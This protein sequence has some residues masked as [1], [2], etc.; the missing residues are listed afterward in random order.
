MRSDC[1]WLSLRPPTA[2]SDRTGELAS[3]VRA[4]TVTRPYNGGTVTR[5][6][7]GGTVTRT[8]NV[9]SYFHCCSTTS[10]KP[11]PLHPLPFVVIVVVISSPPFPK[12][13]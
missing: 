2:G 5:T 6:Y 9:E 10:L 1:N 13:G 4:G 11:L 12:E 3:L 7:N 8:Y